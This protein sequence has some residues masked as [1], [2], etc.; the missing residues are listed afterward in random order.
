M[1]R[2]R[3][4]APRISRKAFAI[5][6]IAM[7][8]LLFT[9]FDAGARS[10][11]ERADDDSDSGWRAGFASIVVDAKTGKTLQ[12]T[13]ADLP[14]HPASLTKI[15]TLYLLF[16]Q[17]EAGRVRLDQKIRISQNA[18]DQAPTKLD[19]DPGETIEVEDAIKALITRSANDVAVAIAEAIAGDEDAFAVLMT[20]KARALGMK[21]TVFKNA[22]GLPDK[23]QVTTARDLALLGRAI[24]DRFPSLYRFFS[25]KTFLWRGEQIANHNRLISRPGVDGIKTGYTRASGFNLVTSVKLNNRA[26]VAVVLGGASASAR[27]E[28]MRELIDEYLLKAYAGER[29]L[30]LVAEAPPARAGNP[31]IAAVPVPVPGSRE[32]M[33]PSAVRTMAIAKSGEPQPLPEAKPGTL[34]VLRISSF[35][36]TGVAPLQPLQV[37]SYA[38]G[39]I[40]VSPAAAA[41]GAPTPEQPK[42]SAASAQPVFAPPPTP[43]PN[44][45]P[46]AVAAPAPTPL[47]ASAAARPG[48][49]IQIGAYA[50]E[51]E[52]KGRIAAARERLAGLLARAEA[53][54][55][56][57]VKGSVEYVRARFAGFSDEAEARKTCDLLKK[58]DIACI[59]VK[60]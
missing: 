46:P 43:A 27:D 56:K 28:R 25:L 59:P 48:W 5:V 41:T 2:S 24:Q 8:A 49:H 52:A 19:L 30:P 40:D 50:D 32:P 58:N 42:V 60:N 4:G 21:D 26:I 9:S 16:E 14:R 51:G 33:R 29:T 23:E 6:V 22:S 7:L 1:L 3:W 13:K 17:I 55:E 39:A 54:T 38:S 12:E 47:V 18:A 34:G 36:N 10:R 57:T 11:R 15:M 44:S 37:T 53:Y 31:R 35:A 45:P 20:R